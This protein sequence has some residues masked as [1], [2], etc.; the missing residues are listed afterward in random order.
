MSTQIEGPRPADRAREFTQWLKVMRKGT[1]L[2]SRIPNGFSNSLVVNEAN[3][4]G[5]FEA[6]RNGEPLDHAEM[7]VILSEHRKELDVARD[8][9]D[10]FSEL[11]AIFSEMLE[12]FEECWASLLGT[13]WSN[14]QHE[15]RVAEME[16]QLESAL[17]QVEAL[18]GDD[19]D[20]EPIFS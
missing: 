17:A 13:I 19:D 9:Q 11:S 7:L 5:V 15:E 10:N 8:L 12:Q 1:Q 16:K 6:G 2:M 14:N 18:E 20:D 4:K 3:A